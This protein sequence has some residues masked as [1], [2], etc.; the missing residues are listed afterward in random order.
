MTQIIDLGKLRF[1]FAG[2]WDTATTYE[3]NDIVKY[4]G[5]IYVYTYGLK[6]STH[7]PV[8]NTYWAL[9]V[10]GF[11][12]QAVY[13]NATA[14]RVGDGV[15]HGGK[16]Y[17]C[18]LDTTGNTPPNA[19]YWSLFADGIQWEGEYVNSTAYQK[20]DIVSYGG[21][22]LYISKVDTT[23]NLPSDATYW[24]E[25][26]SGISA[27][28]V[29]NAATAYVVG[30][31]VAYGG[32]LYRATGDTTG[33]LPS[34]ASYWVE[35][36]AG[37]K[38]HGAYNAATA[39]ALNDIVNYGGSLYKNILEST[40]NLPTD[41]T[42]W[43]VF[44]SGINPRGNWSTAVDYQPGDVVTHG[45][46]T[47]IVLIAHA[48]TVFTT[49]LAASKWQKYNGGIDW[50]GNWATGIVYKVDDIVNNGGS[51]YIATADHTS[52]SFAGDSGNW[53]AFA[54]AG[55]DVGLTITSQGDV[56]YRNA[57]APAAL[58]AGVSGHVLTTKG[59]N[60]DPV[61]E[62]VAGATIAKYLINS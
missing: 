47:F 50:K 52:G 2:D 11:K 34:N 32:N 20:N 58:S 6:T 42:Y 35:F 41:A 62:A 10:E 37:I 8:D 40:G 60:A 53:Q 59:A 17:I 27:E 19:T 38:A 46:N 31:I 61:W 3:L 21:N 44:L 56:L 29:Y 48:S 16:V 36:I 15:T 12:F 49:D 25:F 39:Y 5:N 28:G 14:Y 1:Y 4:G 43:D 9:M 55:T 30:D 13:A 33:N 45:G 23:G 24:D 26:I 57:T 18:I 51:V 54:N 22:V 7:L